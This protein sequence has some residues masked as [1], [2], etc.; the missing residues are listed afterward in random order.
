MSMEEVR[1]R[2]AKQ[3]PGKADQLIDAIKQGN[4]IKKPFDIYSLSQGLPR[5]VDVIEMASLKAKQGAAPAYVYRFV[6]QSPMVDGRA[7]AYHCSELPFVFY[8]SER[9]SMMTG[10]GPEPMALAEKISD[11]WINFAR[12][13]NPNHPGLPEWPAFSPDAKQT[14]VLDTHCE[15][16]NN[17]D[18]AQVEAAKGNTGA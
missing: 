7:R 13:G 2:I 12:K 3:F 10:G 9:C 6:W 14:M 5:R 11:A 15:V 17:Y 4:T 8:N 16:R 18:Q 1:S